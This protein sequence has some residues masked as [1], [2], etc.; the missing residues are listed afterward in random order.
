M[1]TTTTSQRKVKEYIERNISTLSHQKSHPL[2]KL[3]LC[4][5]SVDGDWYRAVIIQ[6]HPGTFLT[7]VLFKKNA[8]V[9]FRI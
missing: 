8:E 5:Y 1:L 2:G 7:P 9:E 4:K 3:V 6:I